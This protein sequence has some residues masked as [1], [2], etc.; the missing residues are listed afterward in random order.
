MPATQAGLP[1]RPRAIR[2]I[3]SV[4]NRARG[5]VAQIGPRVQRG[6]RLTAD[7]ALLERRLD[8]RRLLPLH[9]LKRQAR[10]ENTPA[11]LKRRLAE[12]PLHIE[13]QRAAEPAG[14]GH[15]RRLLRQV[16]EPFPLL[17]GKGWDGG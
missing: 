2:E 16:A 7:V 9:G 14:W 17:W 8:A 13:A 5:A 3:S 15:G 4:N 6:D 1:A 10:R 12:R 11:R